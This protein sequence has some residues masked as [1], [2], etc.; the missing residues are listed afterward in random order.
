MS[1]DEFTK[2]VEE[3]KQF[4][5]ATS[6][7]DFKRSSA[8]DIQ[9]SS[10]QGVDGFEQ[11]ILDHR[12]GAELMFDELDGEID[13]MITI[14]NDHEMRDFEAYHDE[15]MREMFERLHREASNMNATM[16]FVAMIL[17]AATE[18][19]DVDG[20]DSKDV[21]AAIAKG[22][23]TKHY[24]WY[25]EYTNGYS[26]NIRRSGLWPIEEQGER[27]LLGTESMGSPEVAP[28][29]HSILRVSG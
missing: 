28:L 3:F 5:N 21:E 1:E 23:V 14:A 6:A 27:L 15:T 22:D 16:V 17:Y 20:L 12:T 25:A 13:P 9:T 24:G 8:I 18:K 29:F 2:E 4:L 19:V 10:Y 26:V 11:F 7:S